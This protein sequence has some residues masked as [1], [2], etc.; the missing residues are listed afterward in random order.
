MVFGATFIVNIVSV[1]TNDK[2]PPLVSDKPQDIVQVQIPEINEELTYDKS[3]I[4]D[5]KHEISSAPIIFESGNKPLEGTVEIQNGVIKDYTFVYED[6]YVT[7]TDGNTEIKDIV[8]NPEQEI[9]PTETLFFNVKDYGAKGDGVTDDTMAIRKAVADLNKKGGTLYFPKGT[10][11]VSTLA[12]DFKAIGKL[13]A[14]GELKGNVN[15]V[16]VAVIKLTNTKAEQYTIDFGGSTLKL[17]TNDYP[18]YSVVSVLNCK[19]VEIKNGTLI[20]DAETHIYKYIQKEGYPTDDGTE[21]RKCQEW[22]KSSEARDYIQDGANKGVINYIDYFLGVKKL[23]SQYGTHEFGNGITLS[24]VKNAK[25]T[26]MT[27]KYMI[28]DAIGAGGSDISNTTIDKCDLSYCRRQGISIF[29]SDT[30]IVKN[31]KIYKIG[32][33]ERIIGTLPM[34]GIDI[35]PD[36]RTMTAKKVVVD[37]CEI[38]E[39][40]GGAI[41]NAF[42]RGKD[43][44]VINSTL[45]NNVIVHK[46]TGKIENCNIILTTYMEIRNSLVENCRYYL[47]NSGNLIWM[48]DNI[49]RNCTFSSRD[50]KVGTNMRVAFTKGGELTNCKF[51]NLTGSPGTNVGQLA[52]TW[53]ITFAIDAGGVRQATGELIQNNNY[54]ENCDI[55][56]T[57]YK[58]SKGFGI[59]DSEFNSCYLRCAQYDYID[60]YMKDTV[61]KNSTIWEYDKPNMKWYNCNWYDCNWYVKNK[62]NRIESAYKNDN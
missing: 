22:I 23:T 13:N 62:N 51:Y 40:A 3:E 24:G 36:S 4:P 25:I 47:G 14:N 38:V 20:G 5:G 37:N 10:Y 12:E 11:I 48:E 49:L 35:E 27:I 32:T 53:G 18:V 21:Y 55:W 45:Q 28:G 29:D 46:T 57:L 52:G 30:T 56:A 33:N 2:E 58:D 34:F 54:Y 41:V 31:T 42:N 26:S 8:K 60:V 17:T 16:Y 61:I 44:Q 19:N 1:F 7:S 6:K 39:N 50:E 43:V 9:K 59:N 15:A